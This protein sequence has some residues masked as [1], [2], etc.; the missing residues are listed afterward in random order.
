MEMVKRKMNI[1]GK[2]LPLIARFAQELSQANRP[3]RYRGLIGEQGETE[4]V[5]EKVV[6]MP[7]EKVEQNEGSEEKQSKLEEFANV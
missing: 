1:Y 7:A 4:G 6:A 2:Y 3:P 5:E